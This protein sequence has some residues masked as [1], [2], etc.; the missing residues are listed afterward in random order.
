MS[1]SLEPKV[2]C[3]TPVKNEAWILDRFLQCASTWADHIIIADQGSTDGSLEIIRRYPKVMPVDAPCEDF[4]MGKMRQS[5]LAT[6]RTIPGPRIII[7][8][9]ADEAL[10]ANWKESAE[11]NSIKN[12]KPGTV[13]RFQWANL[14]PDGESVWIPET[15]ILMG[16]VDDD[17]SYEEMPIDEPR[18]P[19]TATS[20]S[21]IMK[22]IRVL[23]YQYTD[24]ARMQSKQRWYQAWELL[25]SDRRPFKIFRQYRH[26]YDVHQVPRPQHWFAGY[27]AQGI[28]MSSV[29]QDGIYRWDRE[30]LDLFTTHGLQPFRKLD[31]WHRDWS[32]YARQIHYPESSTSFSD[33]RNAL[34]KL[35][36]S[37][38]HNTQSQ[39]R[40]LRIRI[41]QNML[42][43]LGW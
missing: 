41:L 32:E 35:V 6:A 30:L 9:D 25:N 28:D 7:A 38:L 20:P 4:N 3:V 19:C 16:F 22:D 40:Q 31:I 13:L 5:I 36:L 34:E 17:S 43:I 29:N 33:P 26:M 18:V 39:S 23:H 37:W 12:A 2:I 15:N 10:S 1:P 14:M 11:W 42:R 21:L 8:L 24:W 27:E